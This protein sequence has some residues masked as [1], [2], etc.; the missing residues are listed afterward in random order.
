MRRFLRLIAFLLGIHVAGL[1]MLSLFRLAQFGALHSMMAKDGAAPVSTAFVK[2]VWF[3]NVI[4][5]YV[6]VVPLAVLLIAAT[7]GYYAKWLR[8][9][10]AI[11]LTVFFIVFMGIAAANIPYFAYFFKNLDSSIF[12]WF[13]YVGT[14]TGMLVGEASYWPYIILFLVSAL[15]F[16]LGVRKWYK[17]TDRCISSPQSTPSPLASR[18][19][20]VFAFLAKLCVS[21]ALIGLCIFGIRGRMGY[22]PIKISQAYYCDDP[23]LNQLGISPTYNLLTS[24]LDDLRKEN[25][26]L[27]L[28]PYDQAVDDVRQS[29][30]ITGVVDSTAVLHRHVAADSAATKPNVVIILM[31]SMS[32]SLM[33]T[34]GQPQPLTPTL[35]SL[36]RHSLAFTHFYSAGIHTNHG[37]TATLYSFPALMMRNLMKGTVTPRRS[38]L[39]TVLKQEGYHNLF[40]MTHESQYD[41]MNAF[42]RTNGYDEIYSQESY[43]A[44]EVAN[45]FGVPDKYL[46]DYAL[47][48]I[49]KAAS[50]GEPFMAT[51]LTI[52]NH[53]PYIVPQWM[54]TRTKEP[55]TQIVEYA[56]WCIGH[57]LAEARQ[58]PWY[59]NTLFVILADHGKLVGEMDSELPQSYNHIPLI[60]FGPGI[61]PALYDGLG[62]QVDVM[63]TL[64]GLMHIGYDYDGFGVDL[65]RERRQQVFYTSDTQIVAR[66][67]ASCFI[68]NPMLGRDFCYDVLPDGRLRQTHDDH[69]FQ[70]LRQYGFAM[71]QTA[72]F[73]QRH[74]K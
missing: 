47:P 73:M 59:A 17:I 68:H 30:G 20:T 53:P 10:A 12:G 21:A 55:E 37:L 56:D 5:C 16:A 40:F 43:P 34:F 33:Q 63:P 7:F 36:Y 24:A 67:S 22:N 28:M 39:P 51:L 60:I 19:T 32:A 38:G 14:T 13:G 8:K 25:A 11:W 66:D 42:F 26:E 18:K 50:T 35:D 44:S 2:G 52:S 15:L 65:L 9:A 27:H 41:N 64:L 23:F 46:F 54:K 3:D 57:F 74:S 31:E 4:A 6:M 58:Q 69:R 45:S 62:T 70:P 49:N 72:E 29:L 48:V 71:V 61:Q 1:L